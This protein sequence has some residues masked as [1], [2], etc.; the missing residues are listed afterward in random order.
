MIYHLFIAFGIVVFLIIGGYVV[1]EMYA[2]RWAA[3]I[4]GARAELDDDYFDNLRALPETT[5]F[6]PPADLPR[7]RLRSVPVQ[8]SR[9]SVVPD[10]PADDSWLEDLITERP[11][12]FSVPTQRDGSAS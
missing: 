5:A 9:L 7:E 1:V 10:P 11:N 3:Y 8:G 4:D 12:P 2:D 6:D